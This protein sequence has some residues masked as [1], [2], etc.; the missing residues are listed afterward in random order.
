MAPYFGRLKTADAER[1]DH[2]LALRRLAYVPLTA[3][4]APYP[5]FSR[6]L[7]ACRVDQ[8]VTDVEHGRLIWSHPGR[9]GLDPRAVA[10]LAIVR[11]GD[12][13]GPDPLDPP[14]D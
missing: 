10:P 4:A 8:V 13:L 9:S 1:L 5:R 11:V 12:G 14:L 7:P 6:L 2:E 3:Y